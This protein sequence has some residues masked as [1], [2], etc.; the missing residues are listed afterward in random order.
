MGLFE[1]KKT[2][3]ENAVRKCSK[4]K[5]LDPPPSVS[6]TENPCPFSS[7]DIAHIHI[8]ERI[9]CIWK[10]RLEE[11]TLDQIDKVAAHEVAHLISVEHDGKHA[12]AQAEI[13]LG[14]WRPPPGVVVVDGNKK[15]S[16]GPRVKSKTHRPRKNVCSYHPCRTKIKLLT[17]RYCGK[18]FCAKHL[19]PKIPMLPPF[20]G[21]PKDMDDWRKDGHPC[22]EYPPYLKLKEKEEL[23]KRWKIL[24]ILSGRRHRVEP[25][26]TGGRIESVE[27]DHPIEPVETPVKE[28]RPHRFL[29]SAVLIIAIIIILLA[30]IWL[31]PAG[32]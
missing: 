20:K 11:L 18:N 27:T 10:K 1:M 29:I 16:S 26:E 3:F 14:I 5:G 8:E 9:I 13:E 30:L 12:Q 15:E 23:D 24:D 17:C 28:S 32:F 31:S 6:I 2:A 25:V 4:E 19:T 22:P 21:K 7:G